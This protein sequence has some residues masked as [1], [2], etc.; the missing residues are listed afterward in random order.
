MRAGRKQQQIQCNKI[1][2][3]MRNKRDGISKIT[4][5]YQCYSNVIEVM[6]LRTPFFVPNEK[7]KYGRDK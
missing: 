3:A 6:I 7:V 4:F 2:L 1:A 5:F